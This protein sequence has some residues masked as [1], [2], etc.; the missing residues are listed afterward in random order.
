MLLKRL[1]AKPAVMPQMSPTGTLSFASS[2]ARNADAARSRAAPVRFASSGGRNGHQRLRTLRRHNGSTRARRVPRRHG[3]LSRGPPRHPPR[4]A[5]P[6]SRRWRRRRPPWWGQ[7]ST[8]G[9]AEPQQQPG[10]GKNG[11]RAAS[12]RGRAAAVPRIDF[13]REP[14]EFSA[15]ATSARARRR[16]TLLRARGGERRALP[17]VEIAYLALRVREPRR[18]RLTKAC[19]RR[20][21]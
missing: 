14:R 18:A 19:A 7:S 9:L 11:D 12:G 15:R 4:R 3:F 17:N 16:R 6:D 10:D 5:G 21:L 20:D 13:H 8:S 1:Y 2:R